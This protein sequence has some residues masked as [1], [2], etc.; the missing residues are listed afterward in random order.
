M[1]IT[2]S[3]RFQTTKR[4]DILPDLAASINTT[5]STSLVE[6]GGNISTHLVTIVDRYDNPVR[7]DIYTLDI[8]INGDGVVFEEND[9]SEISYEIVE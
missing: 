7:G 3:S 9:T 2:D 1:Q 8:D 6:N 5:L 4:I